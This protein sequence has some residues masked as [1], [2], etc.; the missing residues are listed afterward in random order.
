MSRINTKAKRLE[1]QNYF[2]SDLLKKGWKQTN[3]L[4]VKFFTIEE[5]DKIYLKAWRGTQSNHFIYMR[6]RSIEGRDKKI[7]DIKQ[8]EDWTK[9]RKEKEKNN[10]TLSTHAN[11]AKAIRTELKKLF[12]DIKFSVRSDSFSMGNSVDVSWTDGPTTDQINDVIK[13]YQYGSFN[14][15][16]DIYEYTNSRDDIPQAKWISANRTVSPYIDEL[17]FPIVREMFD[18]DNTDDQRI[19]QILYQMS[20]REAIPAGAKVIGLKRIEGGVSWDECYKYDFDMSEATTPSPAAES[21]QKALNYKKVEHKPGEIL[22][23]KYSEKAIAVIGDTKPIKDDLKKLGG[24][25]NFRLSCGPG[26]IFPA[27]KAEEITNYLKKEAAKDDAKREEIKKSIEAEVIK[28]K[29]VLNMVEP[30]P[31]EAIKAAA[32]WPLSPLYIA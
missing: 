2:I 16:E 18:K 14:S 3:Y 30:A 15:M 25:F 4:N 27:S 11:A 10:P 32:A 21:K 5:N 24:R 13:K 31:G 22:L 28:T 12:P 23:I 8:S 9:A 26:W 6:F 19:K 17:L 1:L 7:N 29:E 20:R